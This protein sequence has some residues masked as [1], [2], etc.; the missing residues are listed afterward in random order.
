MPYEPALGLMEQKTHEDVETLPFKG[1]D[2]MLKAF[3][4]TVQRIPNLE[5]MGTRD[6]DQY[7]WITW[8]ETAHTCEHF[9]YGLVALNLAPAVEAEGKSHNFLGILSRN[10][11][12]WY[13]TSIANMH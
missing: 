7:K 2:T 6:G 1:V 13:L 5:F 4:R 10:R 12:E 9:S 8:K 3:R 11:K